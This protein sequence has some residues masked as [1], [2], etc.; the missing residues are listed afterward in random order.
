M[1]FISS[2]GQYPYKPGAYAEQRYIGGGVYRFWHRRRRRRRLG[3]HQSAAAEP[4]GRRFISCHSTCTWKLVSRVR[5]L[6]SPG[7]VW[8]A[9]GSGVAYT[10]KWFITDWT[11]RQRRL[12]WR[13]D[14]VKPRRACLIGKSV[15]FTLTNVLQEPPVNGH[16]FNWAS[17]RGAVQ[18]QT[19]AGWP[20][21]CSSNDWNRSN[22]NRNSGR[23]AAETVAA[24]VAAGATSTTGQQLQQ[25][26]ERRQQQQQHRRYRC[27]KMWSKLQL[28]AETSV[29]NL[30][31]LSVCGVECGEIFNIRSTMNQRCI[32]DHSRSTMTYKMNRVT[33]A[34]ECR[35]TWALK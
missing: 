14:G 17:E 15:S 25:Q 4:N 29:N 34:I 31:A 33:G 8:S 3:W 12:H 7:C 27:D 22:M 11:Q 35:V 32:E 18:Q 16:K 1:T 13:A 9:L 28:M 19:T 6:P 23:W 5:Y 30:T 24:G 2:R 10:F 26:Q 20:L 21:A